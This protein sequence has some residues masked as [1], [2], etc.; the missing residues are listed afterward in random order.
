MKHKAR[1]TNI[2]MKIF[3]YHQQNTSIKH[4]LQAICLVFFLYLSFGCT[5]KKITERPQIVSEIQITP[6]PV[7]ILYKRGFFN[8]DKSTR[9]LLNLADNESNIAAEY[10]IKEIQAKTSYKLKIS[11]RFTTIKIPRGIELIMGHD[12]TIKPEGF[13]IVISINRI[14]IIAN[15]SNGLYYAINVIVELLKKDNISWQAAQLSIEDHPKA[16][17]RA[18]YIDIIDSITINH[19]F[20]KVLV[21]NRINHLILSQEWVGGHYLNLKIGDTTLL[22]ENWRNY[23]IEGQSAKAIYLNSSQI[24]N[25]AIF[26]INDKAL[27]S[28]DS[29]TIL[30]EALWTNTRNLNYNKLINHLETGQSH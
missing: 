5:P 15:D 8:L 9:V 12:S 19:N 6:T 29:L 16:E 24:S 27:L 13:K 26:K 2:K 18:L 3:L 10:L 4:Y 14:K 20:F 17:I 22:G 25:Q 21:K 28:T 1:F 23:L 7:K 30:G 11:D